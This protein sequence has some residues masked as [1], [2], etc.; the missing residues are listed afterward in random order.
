MFLS[1]HQIAKRA[2]AGMIEPFE[3]KQVST[4]TISNVGYGKG[5]VDVK[6]VSY[7]LSSYGYDVRIDREFL[8]PKFNLNA[9]PV[10]DPKNNTVSD[11]EQ[12][13]TDAIIIPPHSFVLGKTVEY[14]RIPRDILALCVGKSTYARCGI[15]VNVTPLEPEWEGHVTIEISN[16][17]V[18]PVV[19]YAGEGIAQFLFA[20]C[21]PY[22]EHDDGS[23][24]NYKKYYIENECNVSYA[25]RHGKYQG[26]TEV[27]PP[28]S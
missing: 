21:V 10:V 5:W 9:N 17:N 25:D 24:G 15:N 7:G 6:K 20:W 23:G 2:A 3:G 4:G 19:V 14:L 12:C 26:Q 28:R 13:N 11:Y 27:T 18:K 22:S 16:M 8:V 1:D